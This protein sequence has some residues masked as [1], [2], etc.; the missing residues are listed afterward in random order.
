MEFIKSDDVIYRSKID[1][2]NSIQM[3][4]LDEDLIQDSHGKVTNTPEHIGAF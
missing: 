2:P 1:G 4:T 3:Y